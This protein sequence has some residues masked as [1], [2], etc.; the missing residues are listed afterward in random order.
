[1][2]HVFVETNW[3]VDVLAPAHHRE[4]SAVRLQDRAVDGE[5]TLHVPSICF[6]EARKVIPNRFKINTG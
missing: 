5:L 4:P 2:R 1:M 6:T 3:V